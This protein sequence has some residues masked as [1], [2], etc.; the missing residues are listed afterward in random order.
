MCGKSQLYNQTDKGWEAARGLTIRHHMLSQHLANAPPPATHLPHVHHHPAL[1]RVEAQRD[2]VMPWP[3]A[4]DPGD[5]VNAGQRLCMQG[6]GLLSAPARVLLWRVA[7]GRACEYLWRAPGVSFS[8][9]QDPRPTP[10]CGPPP[11][12]PWGGACHRTQHPPAPAVVCID[13]LVDRQATSKKK[14]SALGTQVCSLKHQPATCRAHRAAVA[15][16][17]STLGAASGASC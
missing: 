11:M 3:V 17:T 8:S 9:S 5:G 2:L 12:L 14:S 16:S 13:S 10:E 6:K 1:G 4:I 7:A 15:P